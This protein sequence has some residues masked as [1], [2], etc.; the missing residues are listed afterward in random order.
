MR[1][2][3]IRKQRGVSLIAAIFLLTGMSILGALLSRLLLVGI[4]ESMQEWYAS[5]ALYAAESGISWRLYDYTGTNDTPVGTCVEVVPSR[6]CFT[7]TTST[8]TTV[9][10]Q[11]MLEIT[12]TGNAGNGLG[13]ILASRKIVVTV[14]QP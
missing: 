6:A 5:Q 13:N 10:G 2:T 14:M 9:G 4:G 3:P 8:S 7:V 12:S 1:I 11:T